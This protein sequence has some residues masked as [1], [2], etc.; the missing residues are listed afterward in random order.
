MANLIL[1]PIYLRKGEGYKEL[2]EKN[3]R[4][5]FKK[6]AIESLR[7]ALELLPLE[8]W[9]KEAR[10]LLQQL[11]FDNTDKNATA[12]E[13]PENPILQEIIYAVEAEQKRQE[14]LKNRTHYYVFGKKDE[15]INYV[16]GQ[17]FYR[18]TFENFP[19]RVIIDIEYRNDNEVDLRIGNEFIRA[20]VKE[21]KDDS[22]TYLI[23]L[24]EFPDAKISELTEDGIYHIADFSENI[25]TLKTFLSSKKCSDNQ[26]LPLLTLTEIGKCEVFDKPT[27][28]NLGEWKKDKFQLNETQWDAIEKALKQKITYIW[29]PPG[30]GKTKVLA[31][32]TTILLKE[33]NSRILLLTLSNK[34]LDFLFSKVIEYVTKYCGTSNPED[35][36]VRLGKIRPST[37]E[38][39]ERFY[40]TRLHLHHRVVAMNYASLLYRQEGIGMFDYVIVDEASMTPVPLLAACSYFSSKTMVVAGDPR[41]LPPPYPEDAQKPNKYYEKNVFEMVGIEKFD[42]TRGAFLETQYR[43]HRDIGDL[44]SKM[45]YDSRL[46]CGAEIKKLSFRN[47][48]FPKSVYFLDIKGEIE[49][50]NLGM[51]MH[52]R[53]NNAYAHVAVTIAK[54]IVENCGIP[55]EN[56]GIIAP[57]NAQVCNIYRLLKKQGLR[58]IKVNTV[59][60]FQGQEKD[61]IIYDMTDHDIAPSPLTKNPKLLNVAMSRARRFLCIIGNKKYLTSD[62]FLPDM[63]NRFEK[64]IKKG[65]WDESDCVLWFPL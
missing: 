12:I 50:T 59:Y 35:L 33:T 31:A 42:D 23:P 26:F 32:L 2:F 39:I 17:K 22:I 43:M 4:K 64:M 61:V 62:M 38:N 25:E 53:K 11:E 63:R 8:K 14:M 51:T 6:L 20:R 9:K 58:E 48:V 16:D 49:K 56:I 47:K 29:G 34:T 54:R 19:E 28:L 5:K 27:V 3:R 44:I 1:Y 21:Y 24:S 60:T 55:P 10:N 65:E 57:Y 40:N 37:P 41:Q 46:K 36:L 30:T 45:F 13:V 15:D 7:K 18:V 52:N